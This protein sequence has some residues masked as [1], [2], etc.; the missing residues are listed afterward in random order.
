MHTPTYRLTIAPGRG[1]RERESRGDTRI[2]GCKRNTIHHDCSD[3]THITF[4]EMAFH[5]NK[6]DVLALLFKQN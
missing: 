6:L 1:M 4:H 2:S 5:E 3:E